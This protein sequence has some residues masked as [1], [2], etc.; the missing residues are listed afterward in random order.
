MKSFWEKAKETMKQKA[1]SFGGKVGEYSKY[2]KLSIDKYN[3][4][5]QAEKLA[6]DLGGRVYALFTEKRL[7]DLKDD[8]EALNYLLKLRGLE[9][10]IK[11]VEENIQQLK[12]NQEHKK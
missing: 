7:E 3:L 12:E 5:K 11:E 8:E 9:N 4:T 6:A 1:S 2:S 10:K